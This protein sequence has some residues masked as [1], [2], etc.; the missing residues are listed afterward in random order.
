MTEVSSIKDL[1]NLWPARKALAD[2][3]TK[4]CPDHPVSVHQVNKWAEIGS[5]RAQFHL[6]L[7]RCAQARGFP[8]TAELLV[9]L[10]APNAGRAA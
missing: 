7:L 9:R 4:D 10:H 2:E 8:V 3:M 5:I 6:S 1:I